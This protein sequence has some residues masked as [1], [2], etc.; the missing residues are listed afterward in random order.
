MAMELVKAGY[1]VTKY[2]YGAPRVG[3]DAYAAF[4]STLMPDQYRLTHYQDIVPH[5]PPT[6][7][8]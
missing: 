6:A 2:D 5:E 1:T 4:S 7:P 3:N 8:I